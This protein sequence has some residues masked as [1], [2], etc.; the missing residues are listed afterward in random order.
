[1]RVVYGPD[2]AYVRVF[3]DCSLEYDVLGVVAAAVH[4]FGIVILVV[5][6]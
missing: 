6:L 4:R 3:G 5:D 1:M 2:W